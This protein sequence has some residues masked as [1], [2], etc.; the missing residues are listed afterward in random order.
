MANRAVT[1]IF[2]KQLKRQT[3][4]LEASLVNLLD[5]FEQIRYHL[6]RYRDLR[7]ALD[8]RESLDAA[9]AAATRTTSGDGP[10][11]R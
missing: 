5:E 7:E 11:S 1:S 2:P 9:S 10:W 3:E 8:R 6:G 4:L